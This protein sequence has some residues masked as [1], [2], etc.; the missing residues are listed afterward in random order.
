MD[1]ASAGSIRATARYA[2]AGVQAGVSGALAMFA[3]LMIAS[4]WNHRSVW[5]VPNLFSTTFFG[6]DAYRNHFMGTTAS[7]IALMLTIYGLA[8]LFW[9]L[10][11]G[12]LYGEER[13]PFIGLSGAGA[14]LLVY[15]LLFSFFWKRANPLIP[16]YAPAL[17]MQIGHIIWGFSLANFPKYSRRIA[18]ANRPTPQ[19]QMA[20]ALTAGDSDQQE[21]SRGDEIE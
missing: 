11:W 18:E 10:L 19:A 5:I 13:R 16:L 3:W 14:G 15:L 1:P 8:G 4:L 6:P 7:G 9:G 20:T 17:Q 2:L 12:F 21:V